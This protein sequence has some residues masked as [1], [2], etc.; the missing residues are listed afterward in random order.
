MRVWA[1]VA[2]LA[3]ALGIAAPAAA[4]VYE[5][6]VEGHTISLAG[7]NLWSQL[8]PDGQSYVQTYMDTGAP[9]T[10]IYRYDTSY[11]EVMPGGQ[12]VGGRADSPITADVCDG[13]LYSCYNTIQGNMCE[14]SDPVYY[15]G[16]TT[17]TDESTVL[18]LYQESGRQLTLLHWRYEPDGGFMVKAVLL[19]SF[20]RAVLDDDPNTVPLGV[21][22]EGVDFHTEFNWLRLH[23]DAGYDLLYLQTTAERITI[24]DTSVPEPQTWALLLLGFGGLGAV[25]RRR[26]TGRA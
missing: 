1:L 20:T 19:I 25:M 23:A 6:K 10:F 12:R 21:F 16:Q 9:V 22:T 15:C 24:R 13:H 4:K 7:S 8:A 3:A 11:G 2:V 18:G 5:I 26:R 14:P 17:Q